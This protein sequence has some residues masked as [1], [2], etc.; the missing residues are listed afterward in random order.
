M[1]WGKIPLKKLKTQVF[2]AKRGFKTVSKP[3]KASF[4]Q[5]RQKFQDALSHR[6]GHFTVKRH[7]FKTVIMSDWRI[8]LQN[9]QIFVPNMSKKNNLSQF[10]YKY[11]ILGESNPSLSP[12]FWI[13]EFPCF[14]HVVEIQFSGR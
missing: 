4:R 3:S 11:C 1:H 10:S 12:N 7:H 14:T 8:I 13:S 9:T 6:K 5:L 2:V